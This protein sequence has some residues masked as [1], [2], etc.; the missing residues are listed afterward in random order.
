MSRL[1]C[2][3]SGS[4][5]RCA[6]GSGNE[7]AG[8]GGAGSVRPPRPC[9]GVGFCFH[10]LVG[11]VAGPVMSRPTDKA[12]EAMYDLLDQRNHIC[13]CECWVSLSGEVHLD[14]LC[15]SKEGNL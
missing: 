12:F 3:R 5:S 11:S 13:A 6:Q 1:G 9:H 7:R 14:P 10:A 8:G 4:L 15:L 2:G